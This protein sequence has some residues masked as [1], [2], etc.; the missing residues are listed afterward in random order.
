RQRALGNALFF[1]PMVDNN[2]IVSAVAIC[3]TV[4]N[5][6]LKD[7]SRHVRISIFDDESY[8]NSVHFTVLHQTRTPP[9]LVLHQKPLVV[10]QCAGRSAAWP[11]IVL[12][13][14]RARQVCAAA[15]QDCCT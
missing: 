8:R 1:Y 9:L 4:V 7:G 13:R 15:W 10:W 14:L 2:D 11:P 6:V 3:S 12:D 5:I